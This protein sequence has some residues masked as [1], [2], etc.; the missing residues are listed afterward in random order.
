MFAGTGV[1]QLTNNRWGDYTA[2][3][4]DPADDATFW[5]TNMYYNPTGQFLWKTKI[6]KTGGGGGYPGPRAQPT[7]SGDNLIALG[8]YGDL[9]CLNPADGAVRWHKIMLSDFKGKVMSQWGFAESPLIDGDRVICTPGGSEG[10][11]AALDL[12]SGNPLWRTT[13]ITT[14]VLPAPPAITLP[15]TI[16]GTGTRSDLSHPSR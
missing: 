3:C 4:L 2:M 11:M 8:Q 13:A 12:K 5:Y 9:L 16:T 14:G 15:T 10:T 7:V 1:Q 6:G